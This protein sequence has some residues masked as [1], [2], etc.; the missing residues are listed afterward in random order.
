MSIDY[1]RLW[2]RVEA[3]F[4]C[5]PDSVHG[6]THWR[7]VEKNALELAAA[8]GADVDIVRLFAVFHDSRRV[9]D[10]W[11]DTHGEA[12]ARYAERLR[13]E[14]FEVSD[15][16]FDTLVFACR[17]HTHG[18]LSDDPTVA[19]CWDAD[20]LDLW[21]VGFRPDPKYMSSELGRELARQGRRSP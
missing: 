1:P 4:A 12:G 6:P 17:W 13:G 14:Y 8:N 21:R 11:D 7:R 3:D 5:D 2:L 18:E 16:A 20:R 15:S 9:H 19:T 10:D